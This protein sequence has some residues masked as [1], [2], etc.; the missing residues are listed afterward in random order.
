MIVVSGSDPLF[1][2]A[3]KDTEEKE[4]QYE[5]AMK[6][7]KDGIDMLDDINKQHQKD[8]ESKNPIGKNDVKTPE[9][10][11][12]HLSEEIFTDIFK[13]SLNEEMM[14]DFKS[15]FRADVYNAIADVCYNYRENGL[16]IDDI[17]QAIEWFELHFYDDEFEPVDEAIKNEDDDFF[18]ES[19][20]KENAVEDLNEDAGDDFLDK[21]SQSRS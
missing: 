6:E 18:Q 5:E 19:R 12:M 11:K 9:L 8:A 7:N 1:D 21:I 20:Y 3:M 13:G 4:K 16:T 15:D 17:K 2:A 10:K 14:D